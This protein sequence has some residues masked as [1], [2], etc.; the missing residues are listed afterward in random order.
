MYWEL[1]YRYTVQKNPGI[2]LLGEAMLRQLLPLALAPAVLFAAEAIDGTWKADL[3]RIDLPTKV[4]IIDLEKGMY[5]CPNCVPVVNIKADG[6]DQKVKDADTFD[7]LSVKVVDAH[8]IEL[9]YKKDGK[10]MDFSRDTVSADGTHFTEH[11]TQHP[12]DSAKPVVGDMISKRAEKG[13]AGSHAISGGW[14]AEK[15]EGITDNGITL[16]YKSTPGGLSMTDLTGDSYSAKFDGKDYAMKGDPGT[17]TVSVARADANTY[18]E[19]LKKNGK[20]VTVNRIIV[21]P[22]GKT[23]SVTTEDKRQG[24][25]M[26]FA[27]VKK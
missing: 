12:P 9:T 13:P 18:V 2:F 6:T 19:T 24:T 11:F 23:A 1:Q 7:T 14:R 15:V 26:K 16:T 17:D 21:A 3:S 22:D 20:I 10:I 25:I 8:T 27:I 5:S 4:T